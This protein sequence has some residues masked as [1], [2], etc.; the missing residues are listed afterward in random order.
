MHTTYGPMTFVHWLRKYIPVASIGAPISSHASFINIILHKSVYWISSIPIEFWIENGIPSLPQKKPA[1]GA[2]STIIYHCSP[3]IAHK[4]SLCMPF[5][6][7]VS[8]TEVGVFYNLWKPNIF[9]KYIFHFWCKKCH[10]FFLIYFFIQDIKISVRDA[11]QTVCSY[12]SFDRTLSNPK[13][14]PLCPVICANIPQLPPNAH[15]FVPV[16]SIG[17]HNIYFGRVLHIWDPR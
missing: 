10:V 8:H 11:S 7:E 9:R 5:T 13:Y 6:P 2:R 16:A 15:K 14:M 1:V 4:T 3:Y 12:G 17:A